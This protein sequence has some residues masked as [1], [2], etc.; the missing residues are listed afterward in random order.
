LAIRNYLINEGMLKGF[1]KN[2]RK[3]AQP[4]TMKKSNRLNN[5]WNTQANLKG[6]QRRLIKTASTADDFPKSQEFQQIPQ[7]FPTT[8]TAHF[9]WT[10]FFGL[11]KKN[12]L[13]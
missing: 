1:P 12:V 2:I 8:R 11:N 7:R 5:S 10:S 13:S 3:S 4:R 9:P 6:S